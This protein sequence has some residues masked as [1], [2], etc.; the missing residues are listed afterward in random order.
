MSNCSGSGSSKGGATKSTGGAPPEIQ[1][2]LSK[3]Y[4]AMKDT[5][6]SDKEITDFE[7]QANSIT[8]NSQ[9]I[10]ARN[11]YMLEGYH[12]INH[13]LRTGEFKDFDSRSG[14]ADDSLINKIKSNSAKI[15][16]TIN[17]NPLKQDKVMYR[18]LPTINA[19]G[20]TIVDVKNLKIGDK[21][22]DKAIVSASSNPSIGKQF[23]AM[24]MD[25][26]P[27]AQPVIFKWTAKKGTGHLT[28]VKDELEYMYN[29]FK[30]TVKKISTV[31]SNIYGKDHNVT[32]VELEV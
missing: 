8:L 26:N 23:A 28:G 15:T 30:G 16:E 2:T 12:S 24:T 21:F 11:D 18:G 29:G 4:Q 7:K 13:Y 3:G 25:S 22:E 20:K 1:S 31:K 14:K 5:E 32:V 17:N 10:Q 19:D 6:V 27:K 9:Q